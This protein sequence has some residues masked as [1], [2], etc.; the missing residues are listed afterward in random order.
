MRGPL[1]EDPKAA[2]QAYAVVETFGQQLAPLYA[3]RDLIY[4]V[5]Y[6]FREDEETGTY[7]LPLYV[8]NYHTT[9]DVPSEDE[10]WQDRLA[11]IEKKLKIDRYLFGDGG[12]WGVYGDWSNSQN[13]PVAYWYGE[14]QY[15]PSVVR[16]LPKSMRWSRKLT[17][18]T[19]VT[20]QAA[21]KRGIGVRSES[22]LFVNPVEQQVSRNST[23]LQALAE[24]LARGG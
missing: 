21:R 9:E 8:R 7:D 12:D 19:K 17:N 1:I 22:K 6:G 2:K 10:A 5:W 24:R 14:Q 20:D 23:D 16:A 4:E 11:V 13:W 15:P 18:R 3:S